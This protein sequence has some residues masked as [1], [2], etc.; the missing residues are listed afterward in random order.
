MQCGHFR[1]QTGT[2][3]IDYIVHVSIITIAMWFCVSNIADVVPSN[4]Y[5]CNLMP[6]MHYMVND[7]IY[8]K[9][10]T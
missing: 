9:R 5:E 7:M 10:I 2:L 1:K 3:L 8:K 4:V 6:K